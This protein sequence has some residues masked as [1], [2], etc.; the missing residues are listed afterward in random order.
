MLI[1][2]M[3]WREADI[4]ISH[5]FLQFDHLRARAWR[6]EQGVVRLFGLRC[7]P[8]GVH[9]PDTILDRYQGQAYAVSDRKLST[10]SFET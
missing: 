2:S 10:S 1:D 5:L 9:N 4:F 3:T 8:S 7:Y 6:R